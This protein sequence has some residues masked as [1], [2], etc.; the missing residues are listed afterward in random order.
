MSLSNIKH[1]KPIAQ[2]L[3]GLFSIKRNNLEF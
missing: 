2:N 3:V 1:G